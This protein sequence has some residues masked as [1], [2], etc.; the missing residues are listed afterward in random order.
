[1]FNTAF[2]VGG[3]A[4]TVQTVEELTGIYIDHYLVLDF[5]GFKDMVDAVDGVEV[6][7]PKA[8]SDAEHDIYFDAGTQTLMARTRSAT[9][10]S[11]PSCRRPATSAG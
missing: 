10:A 9:C 1:M 6:C 2:S 8:V 7:L 4:C 5:N 11:A 3:A